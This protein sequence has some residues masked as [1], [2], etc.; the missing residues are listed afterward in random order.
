MPIAATDSPNGPSAIRDFG[1]FITHEMN[2][3]IQCYR[4][5]R[6]YRNYAGGRDFDAFG[7]RNHVYF[8]RHDD[9]TLEN[10]FSGNLVEVCP[11][12]VFDDKTLM[13]HYTRKWD[14]QTAPSV[15]AHCSLGCNTIAGERYGTLRR[16][17][18]RYHNE[19]NG[20]FLCD[21]GRF[22]YGFVNSEGRIRRS[23]FRPSRD[24]QTIPTDKEMLLREL[25]P[26]L[27]DKPSRIIGI[28]SP[29]ASLESNFALRELV[30]PERFSLGL[31]ARDAGLILS[32][33]IF[34]DADLRI[35][36]VDPRCGAG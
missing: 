32:S 36:P 5:V 17:L 27:A 2:R 9:G 1:P 6:F 23:R 16:I 34:S 3:C 10:E 30:G 24:G 7:S 18:N 15:C 35:Q 12:G 31:S 29:R 28:G 4:C 20:Y 8:G 22:G 33:W 11:T 14:L 19:V 13:P 25:G 21:R 26:L